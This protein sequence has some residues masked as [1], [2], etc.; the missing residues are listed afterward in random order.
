M[1]K[2]EIYVEM[3]R[4]ITQYIKNPAVSLVFA[5]LCNMYKLI[6]KEKGVE[7]FYYRGE[8]LSKNTALSQDTVSRSI[9][10]LQDLELITAKRAGKEG[11]FKNYF[12]INWQKFLDIIDGKETTPNETLLK[13]ARRK[14]KKSSP[15]VRIDSDEPLL[16]VSDGLS[17]PLLKV[18]DGLSEPLL[19]VSD[20]LP[21]ENQE[22]TPTATESLLTYNNNLFILNKILKGGINIKERYINYIIKSIKDKNKDKE[23]NKIKDKIK[24]KL[25]LLSSGLK[26]NKDYDDI[27]PLMGKQ[28][29]SPSITGLEELK[30]RL[31]T[32]KSSSDVVDTLQDKNLE[33][34][35][36]N[37][38]LNENVTDVTNNF[39]PSLTLELESNTNPDS[40]NLD[41][42]NPEKEVTPN[43]T[44]PGMETDAPPVLSNSSEEIDNWDDLFESK[45]TPVAKEESGTPTPV[46]EFIP[47]NDYRNKSDYLAW[48]HS[49][50]KP[51]KSLGSIHGKKEPVPKQDPWDLDD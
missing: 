32:I 39:P 46:E 25:L 7:Y 12:S 40:K 34:K 19:K 22:K 50:P 20:G 51:E 2:N 41:T 42:T 3:H 26:G 15:K 47:E 6:E 16:K 44:N 11:Y 48:Q 23:E 43:K 29:F 14:P 49:K 28:L 10:K 24:N 38:Q 18:S 5:E 30:K 31:E 9:K 33:T 1:E 27:S 35:N 37:F 13:D 8:E 45:N 36:N 17:E 4:A 21:T